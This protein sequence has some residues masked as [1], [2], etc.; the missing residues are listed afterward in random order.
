MPQD[1]IR[2]DFYLG[3]RIDQAVNYMFR[4]VVS[5]LVKRGEIDITSRY[6]SLR[7]QDVVGD[8]QFVILNKTLPY[9]HLLHG[10]PRLVLRLHGW[11]KRLGASE[12]ES[13]GLDNSSFAVE[14]VPLHMPDRPEL[15]LTRD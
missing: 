12:P 2:I 8:F 10:W 1:L 9:E 6:E 4:Q 15:R 5:E 7:G 3:F 14:N 13:F 11:L